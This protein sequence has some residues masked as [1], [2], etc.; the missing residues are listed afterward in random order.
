MLSNLGCVESK[1]LKMTDHL[2]P[3][4]SYHPH[5]QSSPRLP[6]DDGMADKG[7]I[8]IKPMILID[9]YDCHFV[10]CAGMQGRRRHLV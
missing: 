8:N 10:R 2:L 9:S 7:V 1:P 4:P 6:H 5:I 3:N